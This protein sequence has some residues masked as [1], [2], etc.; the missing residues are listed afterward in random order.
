MNDR[1]NVGPKAILVFELG[2]V[3]GPL[4]RLVAREQ[5][6]LRELVMDEAKAKHDVGKN[7]SAPVFRQNSLQHCRRAGS[8]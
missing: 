7:F 3:I 2:H 1:D 8:Y 4:G 5:F 6:L